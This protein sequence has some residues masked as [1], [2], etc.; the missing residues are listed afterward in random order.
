[1]RDYSIKEIKAIEERLEHTIQKLEKLQKQAG[2]EPFIDNSDFIRIFKI[3]NSTA[4]NWR[5]KGIIPYVQIE[6]KIYYKVTDIKELF[7]I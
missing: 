7:A 3:S 2:I 4:K 5:T 6:N 1:M